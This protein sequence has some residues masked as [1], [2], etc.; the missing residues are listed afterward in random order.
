MQHAP[1]LRARCA[2]R[3]WPVGLRLLSGLMILAVM[4]GDFGGRAVA[5]DDAA[6]NGLKETVPGA[7]AAPNAPSPVPPAAGSAEPSPVP[8]PIPQ[9]APPTEAKQPSVSG[10]GPQGQDK[11]AQTGFAGLAARLLPS[12]VNVSVIQKAGAA[13]HGKPGKPAKPEKPA[14]DDE[15]EPAPGSP[16]DEFF[17]DFFDRDDGDKAGPGAGKGGGALGS[18]FIIDADGYV[19]TN[20]HVIADAA[21]ITVI[22]QDDTKLKA[23]L[24]GTDVKTD[25]A[26]LKVT[27]AKPLPTVPW[28]T[29]EKARVGDWVVAIGNPFGLGGT[30]TTGIISAKGRSIATND[31]YDEFIQTDASINQGNSGGPLFNLDGEVIGINSAIFSPSGGSIGIGFAIPSDLAR[32]ITGQIREFGRARRGWLGVRFQQVN[33]AVADAMGL[34]TPHGVLIADFIEG[35]PAKQAGLQQGD[36]VLAVDGK[37]ISDGRRLQRIVA[38]TAVNRSVKIKLWRKRAEK[39]IDV[40]IG[41]LD[42]S[43]PEEKLANAVAPMDKRV[44]RSVTVKSLGIVVSEVT[45]ALREQYQLPTKAIA[46]ITDVV[47]PA[48]KPDPKGQKPGG[49]AQKAVPEKDLK[50]GDAI[51]EI[52]Q[53]RVKTLDDVQRKVDE[54]RKAGRKTILMLIDRMGEL[55]FVALRFE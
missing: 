25:L 51:V 55:R 6:P 26:L 52:A 9:P 1:I 8:T 16:F 42:E 11:A 40:R 23:E 41:E 50:P 14:P 4:A 46:V 27:P 43:E 44:E 39:L 22:L 20:N 29:S 49:A 47:K 18:G 37:E 53:E 54:A 38:D 28:G 32:T 21:D 34:G 48:E 31:P 24:V 33:E 30:V 7:V 5:A 3:R 36:I 12:V 13:P 10:A 35:S 19:V 45:P 2:P 17:K 15:S